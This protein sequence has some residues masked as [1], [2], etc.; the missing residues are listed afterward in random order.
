MCKTSYVIFTGLNVDNITQY[1]PSLD[2]A[3]SYIATVNITE[4]TLYGQWRITIESQGFFNIQVL[5][6]SELIVSTH[7]FTNGPNNASDIGDVKP[8][9]GRMITDCRTVLLL[10]IDTY[11]Y[12]LHYVCSVYHHRK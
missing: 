3:T 12:R 2:T 8:L 1:S 11:Y 5:G 9:Q 7:L 10:V 6:N 4:V